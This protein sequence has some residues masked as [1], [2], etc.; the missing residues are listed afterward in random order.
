MNCKHDRS[1][2][3]L[4]KQLRFNH[5]VFFKTQDKS[6]IKMM[7]LVWL[8]CVCTGFFCIVVFA[9]FFHLSGNVDVQLQVPIFVL[10]P[11]SLIRDFLNENT[12]GN[13]SKI[14][15]NE[16]SYVCLLN[17]NFTQTVTEVC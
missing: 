9:N 3:T 15:V 11:F 17:S 6:A 12:H 7:A 14:S 16:T 10:P 4:A 5:Q 2:R 1:F 13:V 8:F